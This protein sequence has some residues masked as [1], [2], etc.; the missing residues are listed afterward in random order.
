MY[1]TH[2]LLLQTLQNALASLA[3]SCSD[4]CTPSRG[5]LSLSP[6]LFSP[7]FLPQTD[8]VVGAFPNLVY[9]C[10]CGTVPVNSMKSPRL[11]SLSP[12]VFC[13]LRVGREYP[14]LSRLPQKN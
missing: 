5:D 7:P 14:V 9:V 12:A 1:A 11:F 6:V 2:H 13:I 3:T 10:H 4:C 8:K